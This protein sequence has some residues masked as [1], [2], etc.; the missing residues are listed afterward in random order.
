M[1]S[2][3]DDVESVKTEED[4]QAAYG[5]VIISNGGGA[6]AAAT[7]PPPPTGSGSG[8]AAAAAMAAIADDDASEMEDPN[9]L[10]CTGCEFLLNK[11]EYQI[12]VHPFIPVALCV[13]CSDDIHEKLKDATAEIDDRCSWCGETDGDDLFICGDGTVC[14]HN[15]CHWCLEK[16]LGAGF[17]A[18]LRAS[19]EDWRCLACDPSQVRARAPPPLQRE[20]FRVFPHF[21]SFFS[22]LSHRVRCCGR[23]MRCVRR[24]R[25]SNA[26]PCTAGTCARNSAAAMRAR[27]T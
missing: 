3:S 18:A 8:S 25:P 4:S 19:D 12:C 21:S 17:V 15:F 1:E 16:N 9:E 2:P 10:K 11:W 24:W 22:A 27:R 23:W 6:R 26:R 14:K 13:V 5:A 7:L 20:S